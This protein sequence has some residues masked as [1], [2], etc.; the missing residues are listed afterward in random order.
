MRT[1]ARVTLGTLKAVSK[2]I[3]GSDSLDTMSNR[4]AQLLVSALNIKGCAIFFLNPEAKELE[5]LASFGLS[6]GYLTKGPLRA[7]KSIAMNLEGKPVIIADVSKDSTLQYPDEAKREGISAVISIPI[8]FS[9]EIIGVLRLYH[10]EVWDLC[11]EDLD[12]L[13]FLAANVGLAMAYTRLLNAVQSI[14]DVTK[15]VLPGP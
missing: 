14:S 11:G 1:E 4:L 12:S 10:H 6:P 9:N 2:A 13:Q 5:M 7:D 8:A 3:A 15:S